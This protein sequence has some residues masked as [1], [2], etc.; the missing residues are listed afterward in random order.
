[1]R[2]RGEGLRRALVALAVA[3]AVPAA[4]WAGLGRLRVDTDLSRSLPGEDPVLEAAA[5]V[6]DRHPALDRVVLDLHLA[7][8]AAPAAPARLV[9]AAR[10]VEERLGQSG[11]FT[12][13]GLGQA[14]GAYPEL[15][16]EVSRNL[17]AL[18]DRAELL[19]EV[20]PRLE[21]QAVR[22]A[23]GGA[24]E[25]LSELSGLGQAELLARDPLR[26]REL[27]LARL[28]AARPA[29]GA[30]LQ[31]GAL[32]DVEGRHALVLAEPAGRGSDTELARRIAERLERLPG[33]LAEA[34]GPGPAVELDAVGSFRAALDNERIVRHDTE[35]GVGLATLGIALLLLLCFPRPLLGLLGLLPSVAGASLALLAYSF[36]RPSISALALGFGGA[37]ISITVDCSVAF[38]LHLDR[39]HETSGRAVARELWAPS[40]SAMLTTVGAFLALG[41]SGFEMLAQMGLFASLGALFSFLFVHLVFPLL[42]PR[43]GPAR[44]GSLL[45]VERWLARATTGRGFLAF[46]LLLLAGAGLLLGGLPRV[47]ANLAAMNTVRPE[48]LAAEG[49]VKAAWGDLGASVHLLA[50]AP[51]LEALRA[52]TD[53]LAEGLAAERAAGRVR[54]GLTPG[55]LLPGTARAR[56][57]R[58]AWRDFFT[59]ARRAALAEALAGAE[60]ELGFAPDAFA[61][62]LAALEAPVDG[63]APPALSP[64]VAPLLGVERAAGGGWVWAGQAQPAAGYQAEVFAGALIAR[65]AAVFDAG[66]FTRRLSAR[67]G[68]AYLKMLWLMGAAISLLVLLVLADG[69]LC[70][71]ALLPTLFTFAATLGTLR[72]LGRPLDIPG[73]LLLAVVL[74]VGVDYAVFYLK[75]AQRALDEHHP[76]LGPIRVMVLLAGGSTL[77]GMLSMVPSEHAVPRSAGIT[78]SLGMAGALLGTFV[79]LPPLLARL[80]RRRPFPGQALPAGS[81]AHL[82]LV[83]ARY[84]WLEPHPRFFA[85]FKLAFDPLFARLDALVGP[86]GRVLDV[87][88]GL[89][90]PAAFL[91]ACRPGLRLT[92]LEPDPERARVAGLVV[93]ERGEVVCAAAPGLSSAPGPYDAVL[94]LDMLHHLEDGALDETLAGVQARLAPGGRVVLRVTVPGQGRFAWERALETVRL[95]L[96]RRRPHFRSAAELGA[97]LERAGLRVT[98]EERSAPGREETWFVAE[99]AA[100]RGGAA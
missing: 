53:G 55:E 1:M 63:A 62:F 7:A 57:Q 98:L 21:P 74:G 46:G 73:L 27:V 84:R 40:L 86:A 97:A 32:L 43:L 4:F 12:R 95:R 66:L 78:T 41:L 17:P 44:R 71:V 25:E 5:R 31:G 80:L 54:G 23:L 91:L 87:G 26:L 99:A 9:Q 92:G 30:R 37:L 52:A 93:G 81:R 36:L 28:A 16:D 60:A 50:E 72:L 38:L 20:A 34:L 33:E 2:P 15:L 69:L 45:P 29:A 88:C 13:V 67:I 75:G 61:P 85:R 100:P 64:A 47:D 35:R 19:A 58:Q 49:R 3:V 39:H 94:L 83:R 51:E 79:L 90:V 89:G 10:L 68:E 24:L 48:T 14:A 22:A 70:L 42:F 56:A 59:P 8:G 76:S 6:V 11:L 77:V 96:G 18:F 65:G 82:A